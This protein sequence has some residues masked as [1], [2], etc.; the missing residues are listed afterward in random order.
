MHH[1]SGK[2]CELI[3]V[4]IAE[5][6]S[7]RQHISAEELEIQRQQAYSGFGE[8]IQSEVEESGF[9]QQE[10]EVTQ[11]LPNSRPQDVQP[12][13]EAPSF[14]QENH[15]QLIE[16]PSFALEEKEVSKWYFKILEYQIKQTNFM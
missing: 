6:S 12:K 11:S 4:F 8:K 2:N 10:K 5:K 9:V 14:Q 7:Q 3:C 16:Q 1:D 13:E 15:E